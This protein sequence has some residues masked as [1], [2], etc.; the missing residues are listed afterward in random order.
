MKSIMR[1]IPF[2]LIFLMLNGCDLKQ[3]YDRRT[4]PWSDTGTEEWKNLEELMFKQKLAA[5]SDEIVGYSKKT[6]TVTLAYHHPFGMQFSIN[7]LIFGGDFV[8]QNAADYSIVRP[9]GV[10]SLSSRPRLILASSKNMLVLPEYYYSGSFRDEYEIPWYSVVTFQEPQTHITARTRKFSDFTTVT[11][12]SASYESGQSFE[13]IQYPSQ[14]G[15]L[16]QQVHQVP[17]DSSLVHLA[18]GPSLVTEFNSDSSSLIA[19]APMDGRYT[20]FSALTEDGPLEA[21]G[22]WCAGDSGSTQNGARFKALAWDGERDLVYVGDSSGTIYVIDPL[23]CLPL[24]QLP[25]IQLDSQ[26]PIT[27]LMIHYSGSLGVGQVG[28]DITVLDFDGSQFSS[29]EKYAE[30]CDIP[31]ES[32]PVGF[33]GN[34]GHEG[35]SAY[36]LT[37]CYRSRINAATGAMEADVGSLQYVSLGRY[38]GAVKSRFEFGASQTSGVGVYP[39]PSYYNYGLTMDRLLEGA[40]GS[41][42]TWDILTGE[43]VIQRDIQ[44]DYVL[45]WGYY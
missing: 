6:G 45:D 2:F 23:N 36:L 42:E 33:D 18:V 35:K 19:F 15:K 14:D 9:Q 21:S 39:Y 22:S 10:G 32:Y 43:M 44:L 28:G 4:G 11:L 12:Y 3:D 7:D 29:L 38:S 30:I 41:M 20:L 34:L 27:F 1:T 24:D 13:I 26:E 37:V 40:F 16:S 31:M 17:W 25:A 5:Y 8:V